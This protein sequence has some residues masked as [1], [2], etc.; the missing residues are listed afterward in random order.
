MRYALKAAAVMSLIAIAPGV[1]SAQDPAPAAPAAA[2]RALP[3][4][5][6][7]LVLDREVYDYPVGQRRDPFRPLTNN[8]TSGPLFTELTMTGI[9]YLANEPSKSFATFKDLSKKEYRVH[10][11]ESIGNATVQD[12]GRTRVV[13]SIQEFGMKHQEVLELKLTRAGE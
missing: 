12:I 7:K 13:F 10:R 9:F 1:A 5:V 11:G 8:D 6:P 2:P 4:P 3:K